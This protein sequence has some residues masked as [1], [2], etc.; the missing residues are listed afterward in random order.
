MTKAELKIVRKYLKEQQA[1]QRTVTQAA[2]RAAKANPEDADKWSFGLM[3]AGASM[4]WND[5]IKEVSQQLSSL[6]SEN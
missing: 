6:P 5:A 1:R 4:A 2:G 3:C